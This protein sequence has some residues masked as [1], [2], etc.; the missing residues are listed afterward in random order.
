[1]KDTAPQ[2]TTGVGKSDDDQPSKKP[3]AGALHGTLQ[4]DGKPLG[5]SA[6]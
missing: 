5:G 6:S 4:V 2:P 1:M 3:E